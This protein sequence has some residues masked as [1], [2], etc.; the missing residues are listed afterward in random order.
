[1]RAAGKYLQW[2]FFGNSELP[3]GYSYVAK[4]MQQGL[5]DIGVNLEYPAKKTIYHSI[6]WDRFSWYDNQEAGIFTMWEHS[7]VPPGFQ[8]GMSHFDFV[9]TPCMWC[10][11]E[12][13]KFYLK[14]I[15]VVPH[16]IDPKTYFPP[17]RKQR[18]PHKKFTVLSSATNL[19]K[20]FPEVIEGFL[21]AKIPNSRL[22]LKGSLER[23]RKYMFTIPD[24]VEVVDDRLS[25]DEMRSLYQSADL[26]I[27]GSRGEGWDLIAFEALACG[28]VTIVPEH[29]GY[30]DWMHLAQ[31]TLKQFQPQPSLVTGFGP[32]GDWQ[33]QEA[34]EIANA[35]KRVY[36]NFPA[37]A[38]KA[39]D[40]AKLMAEQWTWQQ[41][42]EK[43]VAALGSLPPL[44]SFGSKA[45]HEPLVK[46]TCVRDHTHFEIG[47]FVGGP[48]KEGAKY[49]FPAEVARVLEDAGY[50]IQHGIRDA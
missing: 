23:I 4:M 29:T 9:V 20:G 6:P 46:V 2:N 3:Q 10:K 1:M 50:V 49:K 11:E 14:P 26:Y 30:L 5:A 8:S 33:V 15:Y 13:S 22:V 43:L 17:R 21:Q 38:D 32:S 16:G 25:Y 48:L 34:S 44:N 19:R 27:S 40:S 7:K 31:G 12:F 35:I 28:T 45:I 18:K 41:S 39:Y 37:Y 24:G 47:P 36:K 42:A